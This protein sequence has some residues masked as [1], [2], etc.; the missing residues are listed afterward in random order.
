M[1]KDKKDLCYHHTARIKW[2]YGLLVVCV[3]LFIAADWKYVYWRSANQLPGNL[4]WSGIS[5]GVL[6]DVRELPT[7]VIL[8]WLV[9]LIRI[10]TTL[11]T[12][13]SFVILLQLKQSP[14]FLFFCI[15]KID[16][17][18]IVAHECEKKPQFSIYYPVILSLTSQLQ[19]TQIATHILQ[20]AFYLWNKQNSLKLTFSI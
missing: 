4:I 15:L 9:C 19:K 20:T 14:P 16:V 3:T 6:S 17:E 12:F 13:W 10:Q 1:L 2:I 7:L 8:S 18:L 11:P 5:L